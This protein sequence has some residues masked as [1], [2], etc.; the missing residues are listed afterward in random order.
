MY[1]NEIN[2]N[3]NLDQLNRAELDLA[4]NWDYCGVSNAN[5]IHLFVMIFLHMCL[6]CKWDPVQYREYRYSLLCYSYELLI[7]I[8]LF[9]HIYNEIHDHV[10]VGLQ[11]SD[12]NFL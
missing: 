4:C 8:P 2:V 6:Y 10:G 12:L 1:F 11:V 3:L 9:N 5:D 7:L